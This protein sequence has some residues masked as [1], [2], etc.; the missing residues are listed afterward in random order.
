[1]VPLI[2]LAFTFLLLLAAGRAGVKSL[3]NWRTPLR[4]AFAAMF[5]LTASAHFGAAREEMIRMVPPFFPRPD[6]I[7]LVTGFL[8]IAGA[9]GLVV[10][11]TSRAAAGAL[12]IMVMAM[13]PANVYA[14][15]NDLTLLG[16][17]VTELPLRTAMQI[18]FV[19]GLIAL[20]SR[21]ELT[22]SR[23]EAAACP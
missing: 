10:P 18:L 1:M 22:F 15:L 14:A 2:V 23:G 17:P 4:F 9:A 6:L 11:R 7:V 19:A 20:A 16:K 8:E 3:Q 12:A 5:L 21:R 13:F